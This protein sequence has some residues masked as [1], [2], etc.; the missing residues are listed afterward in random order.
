MSVK[1]LPAGDG[2]DGHGTPPEILALAFLASGDQLL[3]TAR[4]R[5]L[6]LWSVPADLSETSRLQTVQWAERTYCACW[7]PIAGHSRIAAGQSGGTIRFWTV[8]T[9]LTAAEVFAAHEGDV[10]QLAFSP[11][12]ARL[13]SA[14]DDGKVRMWDAATRLPIW[15]VALGGP[16]SDLGFSV[17]PS[18]PRLAVCG[19]TGL[20]IYDVETG[21]ELATR[22]T[23][24]P[25]RSVAFQSPS[26]GAHVVYGEQSGRITVER[27]N[28]TVVQAFSPGGPIRRL[29][30]EPA[31]RYLGVLSGGNI[32]GGG[33]P[34]LVVRRFPAEQYPLGGPNLQQPGP[35]SAAHDAFTFSRLQHRMAI[36]TTQGRSMVFP[37]N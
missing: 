5:T 3:S 4:D 32:G 27:P 2:A 36:G 25:V 31:G 30:F 37:P 22:P 18:S 21:S 7:D 6:C 14:G 23:S 10:R 15:E 34:P 8:D 20:T 19:P 16:P 29:R 1:I 33:G 13:A 11:S 26:Y 35:F 9:G 17:N 24:S 28:G 12:G